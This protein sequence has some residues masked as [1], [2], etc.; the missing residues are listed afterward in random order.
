M[1]LII[2]SFLLRFLLE[3]RF[4]HDILIPRFGL[5][6]PTVDY[7]TAGILHQGMVKKSPDPV[8]AGVLH[9]PYQ[10]RIIDESGC[11]YISQ[12]VGCFA[13]WEKGGTGL[14]RD[15]LAG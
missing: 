5:V 8:S 10:G 4:F 11:R 1:E 2:Y 9:P 14:F 13:F 15:H 12:P 7:I 3:I 6:Q